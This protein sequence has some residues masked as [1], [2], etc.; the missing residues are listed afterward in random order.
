MGRQGHPRQASQKRNER[1]EIRDLGTTDFGKWNTRTA[2]TRFVLP[3]W[4][5]VPYVATKDGT[6]PVREWKYTEI[7]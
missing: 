3:I 5:G 7:G 1:V 2:Y 6:K 4:L